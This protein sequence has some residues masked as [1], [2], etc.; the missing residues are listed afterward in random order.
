MPARQKVVVQPAKGGP[1]WDVVGPKGTTHHT[2]KA[3]AVEKGR[4]VAKAIPTPSQLVIKKADGKIQTE[5]TYQAD[6]KKYKG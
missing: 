5:H 1:G 4:Q 6:P 2:A 3:P